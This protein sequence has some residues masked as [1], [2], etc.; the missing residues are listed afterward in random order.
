MGSI[1]DIEEAVVRIEKLGETARE[2]VKVST[3]TGINL[4]TDLLAGTDYFSP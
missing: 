4:K 1:D 3:G 2:I